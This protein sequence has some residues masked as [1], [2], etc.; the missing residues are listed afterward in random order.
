MVH[1]VFIVLNYLIWS[2]RDVTLNTLQ[3]SVIKYSL[4]NPF[5]FSSIAFKPG[6]KNEEERMVKII[7]IIE[8]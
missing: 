2:L 4:R 8:I 6:K 3:L 7:S 1:F 5:K